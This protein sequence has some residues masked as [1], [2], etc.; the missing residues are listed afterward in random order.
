MHNIPPDDS[1]LSPVIGEM[2]M[3]AL[4][5]LLVSIFSI[6]LLGLLPAE[7]GDSIDI[8]MNYSSSGDTL[9][10]WHKGGDWVKKSDLKVIIIRGK[11]SNPLDFELDGDSF[12][13]GDNITLKN[14]NV[15]GTGLEEGDIVRLI[16][17]KNVIYS[18]TIR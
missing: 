4:A 10:L 16:N 6:T 8:T 11:T 17:D 15:D 7:R 9:Q 12:D 13:L 18:G 3:I 5:L 1:A 2:M 14:I